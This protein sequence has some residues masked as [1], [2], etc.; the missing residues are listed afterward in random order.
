MNADPSKSKRRLALE[1]CHK[2]LNDLGEEKIS[3]S[4]S[5]LRFL[6]ITQLTNDE[7]L[8]ERIKNELDGFSHVEPDRL[9]R[10]YAEAAKLS[11]KPVDIEKIVRESEAKFPK[12]R[13]LSFSTGYGDGFKT[14]HMTEAVSKYEE[15]LERIR[16]DSKTSY[17]LASGGSNL[18]LSAAELNRLVSGCKRWVF[19]RTSSLSE[20]LEFGQIPLAA[21]EST[22]E[23]VDAQLF[24]LIPEAAERLLVAYKNLAEK[25]EENWVNVVDTC[26]RVVKD[27]ADV[28][29]PAKADPVDGLVVTDD[30]YLNRIR[31]FIKQQVSSKRQRDHLQAILELIG[32][33]ITRTDNLASRSVH[34]GAVTRF[35]AERILIYTYLT[36]GDI[37]VLSGFKQR[38]DA[39]PDR[40]NLNKATLQELQA[41]GLSA[42]IAAAIITGRKYRPYE[43]WED[44]VA[45][46]GIGHNTL[47]RLRDKASL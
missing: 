14:V 23:F 46:K 37:L 7:A 5:L 27:F 15:L 29:F 43:S 44:V 1:L 42:K 21:M 4:A 45:I 38:D 25:S 18:I 40:P 17:R 28:V 41:L 16:K 11:K 33:I 19:E 2:L 34:S 6:R 35:E 32:E 20:R 26:R 24:D 8:S 13:V 22:F 9:R 12:Y 39:N 47:K 10:I 3:A 30:K 36:V 31:A